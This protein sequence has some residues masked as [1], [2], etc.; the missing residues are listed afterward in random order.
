MPGVR[1][2]GDFHQAYQL[3]VSW[4]FQTLK[5]LG[6]RPSFVE[7]LAHDVFVAAWKAWPHVDLARP[8]RPWLFGIAYRVMLDHRRR[9][10]NRFEL[11]AGELP[12]RSDER[13]D[14]SQLVERQQ[15]LTLAARLI[16]GLEF[17]R[18][19]IFVMHDVEEIPMPDVAE[20]LGVGLNTAYSRL[21]LARRDFEQAAQEV[22]RGA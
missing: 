20:A 6:A 8:L 21:R 15:G 14:P 18:R 4:L 1:H 5:R 22:R 9:H 2:E 12:E 16:A 10:Q 3:H 7:D 13:D 17:E 19:A 11:A